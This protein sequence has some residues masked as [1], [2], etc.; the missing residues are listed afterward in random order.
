MSSI[1]TANIGKRDGASAERGE[2]KCEDSNMS[3]EKL[4]AEE[5]RIFVAI[6]P[7]DLSCSVIEFT[8][9]KW[10]MSDHI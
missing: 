7:T 9:V 5:A 10:E 1:I 6:V 8:A 3:K 2:G 4:Q